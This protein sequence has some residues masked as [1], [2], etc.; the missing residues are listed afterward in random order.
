MAALLF[1]LH[2]SAVPI[3]IECQTDKRVEAPVAGAVQYKGVPRPTGVPLLSSDQTPNE[4]LLSRDQVAVEALL[5]FSVPVAR[6]VLPPYNDRPAVE[7]LSR[8]NAPPVRKVL[9][10][11]SVRAAVEAL[12]L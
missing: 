12:L 2:R 6:G 3:R 8:F 5:R 1:V 7:A 10:L 11:Y 9:L 4:P